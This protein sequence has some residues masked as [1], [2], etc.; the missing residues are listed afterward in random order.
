VIAGP[1]AGAIGIRNLYF[2]SAALLGIIAV[3]G[4]MKL[5]GRTLPQTTAAAASLGTDN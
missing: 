3:A 5:R 4:N 1:V 2:A